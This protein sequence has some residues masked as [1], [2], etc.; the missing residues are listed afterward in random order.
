MFS[1]LDRWSGQSSPYVVNAVTPL[2]IVAVVLLFGLLLCA[3]VAGIAWVLSRIPVLGTLANRPATKWIGIGLL[4]CLL[5]A[6]I[7]MLFRLGDP[8]AAAHMETW[9]GIA[10]VSFLGAFAIVHLISRKATDELLTA[11]WEGPLWPLAIG[12]GFCSVFAFVGILMSRQPG[13]LLESLVRSPYLAAS[14]TTKQ[15]D[16]N[17]AAPPADFDEP[18]EQAID[19]DFR[20]REISELRF[21]ST[22]RLKISM[23]PFDEGSVPNGIA[24]VP[25][26]EEVIW[27]K[28]KDGSTPFANEH[29]RKLY[30]KNFGTSAANLSV[31]AIRTPAHPEMLFVPVLAGGVLFLFVTYLTVRAAFPKLAAVSLATTKSEIVQPLYLVLLLMGWLILVLSIFLPYNTFGEDLKVLED[32]GLSVI[33]ILCMIHGVW[34]ASASVADEI[35]GKTALTLLSKPVA[36]RD[37]V[38]GKFF[39]ILWANVILAAWLGL[40]LVIGV[41]Y[42][43]PYDEREGAEFAKWGIEYVAIWEIGFNEIS[44]VIPGIVLAFMAATVLT[45]IS[46]AL[47][48]RL[49]TLA[50]LIVC[51][52][53]YV[54]GNLIS[55]VVQAQ[56]FANQ[57]EIVVVI[58]RVIATVVPV[59]QQFNINA[60]IASGQAVPAVYVAWTAVYCVIYCSVAMLV[61]LTLFEDRD[62]A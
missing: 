18:P 6:P 36:R 34:A 10:I 8:D 40:W 35:E 44:H 16:I 25:E 28:A 55:T 49:P 51:V 59:F 43:A 24:T 46:V 33:M 50:N 56:V 42:K 41:A 1:L 26:A 9:G 22:Q 45:S 61:A 5:L 13:T 11:I 17:I 60:A 20:R 29:V 38:L 12:I 58:A 30:V 23:R 31:T 14:G 21:K 2:W 15:D 57:F 19:V 54:V 7:S 4:F 27:L 37:F 3:A 52:A 32:V 48:T 53:V 39:G 47:S 62:L